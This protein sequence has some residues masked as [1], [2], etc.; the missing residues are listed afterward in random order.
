MDERIYERRYR[1]FTTLFVVLLFVFFLIVANLFKLSIV[2]H[3]YYAIL[4]STNKTREVL[5][6]PPRGVFFDRDNIPLVI[7]EESKRYGYV[8]NYLFPEE[9]AHALGYVGLPGD[10]NLNDYTCGKSPL[11]DHYMGK[12]GLEKYFECRLRGTPGKILYEINARGQKK[13]ALARNNPQQGENTTL[14]LSTKL[15]KIA[16]SQFGERKGAVIASNPEN[17]EVYLFYSSPSY[18]PNIFFDKNVGEKYGILVQ[19][20]NQPLLNRLTQALYPP[21][22]VIKPFIALAALAEDVITPQTTYED[23]GIF[24]FGGIEFGNWYF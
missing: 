19:N 1:R 17:G 22:S 5:V 10:D 6:Q 9:Y 2:A 4:A 12:I 8:R 21:G 20:E 16:R 24:K 18:N 7:N 23:T 15:Q 14:S 3:N 11:S 13:N